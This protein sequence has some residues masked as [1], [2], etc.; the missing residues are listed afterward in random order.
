MA[1]KVFVQYGDSADA[2]NIY[3]IASGYTASGIASQSQVYD[4]SKYVEFDETDFDPLSYQYEPAF[5]LD[6][7]SGV[8]FSFERS[9]EVAKVQY[10]QLKRDDIINEMAFLDQPLLSSQSALP[11]GSR[12][13]EYEIAIANLNAIA[14]DIE[15]MDS[16]IDSQ[17]TLSGLDGLF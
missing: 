1:N 2:F 15:A 12:L 13:Q 4:P 11:S 3:D 6:P 7:V 17:T 5:S 10:R 16:N 14:S 8:V 9:Q